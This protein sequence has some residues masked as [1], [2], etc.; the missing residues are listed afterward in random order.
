MQMIKLQIPSRE[1]RI[2]CLVELA[3]RGRLVCPP[4]NVFVVPEPA[5]DLLRSLQVQFVELG[6]AR[7]EGA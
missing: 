1:D 4:E 6:R 2:K 3:R 7:S 5:L